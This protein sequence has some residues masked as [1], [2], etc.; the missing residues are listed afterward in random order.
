MC[1]C[2]YYISPT[3]THAALFHNL[4]WN[5][6]WK[7]SVRRNHRGSRLNNFV[8]HIYMALYSLILRVDD[9]K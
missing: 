1:A 2:K 9:Q 6:S 4:V 5:N 3:D 7:S 8:R